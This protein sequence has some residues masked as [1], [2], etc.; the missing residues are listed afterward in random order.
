MPWGFLWHWEQEPPEQE[1][2]EQ[3]LPEQEPPEQEPP[4]QEPPERESLEQE[5]P[6]RDRQA[7]DRPLVVAAAE[8]TAEGAAHPHHKQ[9]TTLKPTPRAQEF[10]CAD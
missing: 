1:P 8:D 7:A 2:P 4:E 10:S 3:E 9:N 5:P 6:E